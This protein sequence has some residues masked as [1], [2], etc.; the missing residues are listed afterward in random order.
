[1]PLCAEPWALNQEIFENELAHTTMQGA[2]T[3]EARYLAISYR[4]WRGFNPNDPQMARLDRSDD[5]LIEN[6]SCEGRVDSPR[7]S[8]HQFKSLL[9]VFAQI[10]ALIVVVALGVV[11]CGE[12]GCVA[13]PYDLV[14]GWH[15]G[16][17]NSCAQ[18]RDQHEF[19]QVHTYLFEARGLGD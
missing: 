15:G 12:S 10:F 16:G 4:L 6:K 18:E 11:V 8:H 3:A 7:L 1:V 14:N 9:S 13:K 2:A 17:A 19:L 5:K